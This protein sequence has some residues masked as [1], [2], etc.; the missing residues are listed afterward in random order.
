[1]RIAAKIDSSKIPIV[2]SDGEYGRGCLNASC[3]LVL[4]PHHLG[5][6]QNNCWRT[7]TGE[8]SS[9]MRVLKPSFAAFAH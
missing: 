9:A 6:R 8:T 5:H 7:L 1:M 3:I 4:Q 2:Q